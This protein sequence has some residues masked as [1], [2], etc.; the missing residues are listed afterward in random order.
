M[1]ESQTIDNRLVLPPSLVQD[2]LLLSVFVSETSAE[3]WHMQN[4]IRNVY[5][6]LEHVFPKSIQVWQVFKAG[7]MTFLPEIPAQLAASP[8]EYLPISGPETASRKIGATYDQRDSSQQ[9]RGTT[10]LI[11]LKAKR[12]EMIRRAIEY[13]ATHGDPVQNLVNL[14]STVTGDPQRWQEIIDAPYG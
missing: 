4:E 3:R 7:H 8:L 14:L 1:S 5:R 2:K 13:R 6:E 12:S 9:P 11:E 10:L